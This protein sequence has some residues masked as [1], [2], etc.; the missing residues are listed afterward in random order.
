[1]PRGVAHEWTAE[2]DARLRA[3]WHDGCH[4]I[5]IACVIGPSP[6]SIHMRAAALGL[7]PRPPG[8]RPA[9]PIETRILAAAVAAESGSV[10]QAAAV[11]GVSYATAWRWVMAARWGRAA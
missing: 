8:A 2:R 10:A 9:H 7:P 1:M 3:L 11:V 6:R 5:E 4:V